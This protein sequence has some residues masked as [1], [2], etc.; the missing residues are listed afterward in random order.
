MLKNYCKGLDATKE[1][2]L[3]CPFDKCRYDFS[4]SVPR[5]MYVRK[6]NAERPWIIRKESRFKKG[7]FRVSYITSYRG[8][9]GT[10]SDVKKAMK[11]S[12][13][14]ARRALRILDGKFPETAKLIRVKRDEEIEKI[15]KG[16][17]VLA[18]GVSGSDVAEP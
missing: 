14:E 13:E 8:G 16:C 17:S 1:E 12:R 7:G 18:D 10:N 5:K 4:K 2:C 6:D 9:N 15:T 3:N 11:F